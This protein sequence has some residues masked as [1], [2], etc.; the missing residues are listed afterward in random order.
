MHVHIMHAIVQASTNLGMAVPAFNFDAAEPYLRQRLAA[1]IAVLEEARQNQAAQNLREL[2]H[3][4]AAASQLA[5]DVEKSRDA[6]HC[7]CGR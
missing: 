4:E 5:D 6:K 3:L 2:F 1:R 7:L